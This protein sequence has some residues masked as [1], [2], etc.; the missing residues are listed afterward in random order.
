MKT[1]SI[2]TNDYILHTVCYDCAFSIKECEQILAIPKDMALNTEWQQKLL[3][4]EPEHAKL[5]SYHANLIP[6]QAN[7]QWVFDKLSGILQHVNTTYHQFEIDT[8]AGTQVQ[9]YQTGDFQT[10]HV[11]LAGGEFSLRKLGIIVCLTPHSDYQ[12]GRI[13]F[14]GG[15][16]PFLD[17]NQGSVIIFPAYAAF[18][19]EPVEAGKL[20]LLCS[21]AIGSQYFV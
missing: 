20:S 2:P 18:Q 5:A 8:L 12:G 19:I 1:L 6:Y 15:T 9:T 3:A 4:C 16:C 21:W 14:R 11:D 17:Q 10:V 7:N 13:Q